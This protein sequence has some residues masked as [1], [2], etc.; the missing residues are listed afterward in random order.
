[1]S[2]TAGHGSRVYR[3]AFGPAPE[4]TREIPSRLSEPGAVVVDGYDRDRLGLSPGDGSVGEVNGRRVRVV[5]TVRGVKGLVGANLFC[6]IDT[7]RF[8]LRL[9]P[10]QTTYLLAKCRDGA[11][12]ALVAGRL[13]EYGDMAV[14]NKVEFS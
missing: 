2:M 12:A 6:S 5:G 1:P 3:R 8:L 11:D 13:R 4:L 9:P 14:F 7:A 10:D